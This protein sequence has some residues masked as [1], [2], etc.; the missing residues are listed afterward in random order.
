ME[1]NV[2]IVEDDLM[3]QPLWINMIGKIIKNVEISWSVSSEEAQEILR[4]AHQSGVIFDVLI[5][6]IFL[7]GSETGVTFLGSN[8]A[9][10]S[11]ATTVLISSVQA[12]AVE[13]SYRHLLPNVIILSKPLNNLKL[14]KLL[15]DCKRKRRMNA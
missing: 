5:S 3:L 9:Q 14:E 2:L 11:G 6:D 13:K 4:K 15:F 7:A 1:L 12:Q 10:Q 8:L